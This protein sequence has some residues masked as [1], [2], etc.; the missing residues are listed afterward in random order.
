MNCIAIDDEPLALRLIEDYARQITFLNLIG[1]Y[2]KP[3]DALDVLSREKVD[4]IFLDIRMPDM[5]GFQFL[6]SL[7]EKP[8]VVLITAY[9]Q[10]GAESY[11]FNVADYLL[12]PVSMEKFVKSVNKVREMMESKMQRKTGEG[13]QTVNDYI[14]VNSE[15]KLIKIKISDI[16]FIEGLKD[17]IRIYIEGA[18][19]PVLTIMRIKTFEE[20]LPPAAFVR[21]HRSFMVNIQKIDFI[22]K[23]RIHLGNHEIP[24]GDLYAENF[25]K[26]IEDRNWR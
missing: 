18:D 6:N 5:S 2:V 14:F 19:K 3:L 15:Y 24:V 13:L 10:Y 1:T 16:L 7:Q 26:R 21:V 8:L 11:D 17:Y 20:N 22:K 4:L 12:K 25:F 23:N 9:N